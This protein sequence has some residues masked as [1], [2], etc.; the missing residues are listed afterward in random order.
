MKRFLKGSQ[1]WIRLKCVISDNESDE[2][3]N[4]DLYE[5]KDRIKDNHTAT[6]ETLKP[7]EGNKVNSEEI[8]HRNNIFKKAHD[9]FG[10]EFSEE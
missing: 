9:L 3:L 4:L 1:L 6:A 8:I 2:A 5:D 7:E 10:G